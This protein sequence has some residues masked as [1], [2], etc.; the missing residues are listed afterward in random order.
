MRPCCYHRF[1]GAGP[2]PSVRSSSITP[3]VGVDLVTLNQQLRYGEEARL[4]LAGIG[5]ALLIAVLLTL[6]LRL[7]MPTSQIEER[8]A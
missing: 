3:P 6:L 4:A 7:A 2:W 5:L 1:C 8:T